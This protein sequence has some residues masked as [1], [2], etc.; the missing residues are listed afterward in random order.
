MLGRSSGH[1]KDLGSV[2][3]MASYKQKMGGGLS[4]V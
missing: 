1:G 3:G 4:A 2:Y